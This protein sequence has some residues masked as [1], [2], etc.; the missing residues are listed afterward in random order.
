SMSDIVRKYKVN[1]HISQVSKD[2]R[3]DTVVEQVDFENILPFSEF[4]VASPYNASVIE[5]LLTGEPKIASLNEISKIIEYRDKE[6]LPT[7]ARL[8]VKETSTNNFVNLLYPQTAKYLLREVAMLRQDIIENP[9]LLSLARTLRYFVKERKYG[10]VDDIR[11][12]RKESRDF[13]ETISKMLREAR[14]RLEQKEKIHL[15]DEEDVKTVFQLANKDFESTKLALVILSL[16]FPSGGK[17]EKSEI[18]EQNENG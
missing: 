16:A 14:L 15:P 10:Y 7:F 17:E 3:G 18:S 9:A 4:I 6:F 13:E 11:N 12:A 1:F 5:K 2:N 8:Y